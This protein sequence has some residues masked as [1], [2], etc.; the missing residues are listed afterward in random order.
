MAI[1]KKVIITGGLGDI[2]KAI[3]FRLAKEGCTLALLYHTT[4]RADA[5]AFVATLTG[6]GHVAL[7]CDLAD[8]KNVELVI[9]EANERLSG[10]DVAI[11]AAAD[12]LVRKSALSI[13]PEEF[14]TQFEATIFGAL[15]FFQGVAP[16][17]KKAPAGLMIGIT[18]A[19]LDHAES[20]STMAGY[21]SAKYALRGLLRE[22][23]TE[24]ASSTIAVCEVAPGFIPTQFHADLP[25]Q[26]FEFLRDRTPHASV[27][28]I[29]NR[30]VTLLGSDKATIHGNVFSL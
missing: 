27:E 7:R 21:I 26:V 3:A 1:H 28:D 22:L 9:V 18:T 23:A 24:L 15:H 13:T 17:L 29:A 5:D 4:P 12:K 11:H 10:I 25:G 2:G 19:V 8:K 20:K 6:T 30:I 14:K 16:F